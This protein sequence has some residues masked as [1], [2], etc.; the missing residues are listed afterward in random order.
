MEELGNIRRQ[1]ADCIATRSSDL[2]FGQL[3]SELQVTASTLAHLEE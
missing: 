3:H 1:I 2:A